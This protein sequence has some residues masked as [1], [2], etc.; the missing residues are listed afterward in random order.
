M[1]D[2]LDD[3]DYSK[4]IGGALTGLGTYAG[5][6]YGPQAGGYGATE[7]GFNAQ[8][9]LNRDKFLQSVAQ[10]EQA[11]AINREQIA[12]TIAAA[13]ISAGASKESAL[14]AQQTNIMQMRNKALADSIAAK[15]QAVRGNPQVRFQYDNAI[16]G[17]MNRQ[18]ERYMTGF[19]NAAAVLARAGQR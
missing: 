17:A 3:L 5:A 1:F 13:N 8:L 10:Q 6:A 4:I 15:I 12:A 14:I 7:A 9:Q 18:P 2:F 19:N 16:I 11:N